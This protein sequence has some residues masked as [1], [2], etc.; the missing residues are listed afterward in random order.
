MITEKR[1]GIQKRR[2]TKAVCMW[3]K[4]NTD[5]YT[6]STN[7]LKYQQMTTVAFKLEEL[8]WLRCSVVFTF[9]QRNVKVP[10]NI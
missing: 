3:V 7:V 1:S 4:M 2:T 10:I 6:K 8:M 9:S 5:L